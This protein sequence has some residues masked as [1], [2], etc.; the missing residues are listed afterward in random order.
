[1]VTTVANIAG[2]VATD[3]VGYLYVASDRRVYRL[4][5]G[6]GLSVVAGTGAAGFA[7]GRGNQATFQNPSAM[8]I[9]P[10][11][12]LYL[13]DYEG[14]NDPPFVANLRIRLIQRLVQAGTP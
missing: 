5:P 6:G 1:M 12:N 14:R 2:S 11:G 7:D 13:C 9:D 4:S 8:A 10:S 3:S